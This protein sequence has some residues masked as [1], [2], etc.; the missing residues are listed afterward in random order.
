MPK[1]ALCDDNQDYLKFLK[2]LISE[3]CVNHI[4]FYEYQTGEELLNH[5]QQM[6]DVIILD[7][8]LKGIDG[9]SVAYQLRKTNLDGILVFISGIYSPTPEMF[10]VTPFRF[11]P[12]QYD[13]VR[14]R[15]EI[16]DVIHKLE[17]TYA[18]ER[19][20][21]KTKDATA[22]VKIQD[23]LYISKVKHG[24]QVHIMKEKKNDLPDD[25][26]TK[27]HLKELYPICSRHGFEYAHDSYLVN[28][29]WV[30]HLD[31]KKLLTL[32]GDVKLDVSRSKSEKFKRTLMDYWGNK[33]KRK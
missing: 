19:I 32:R 14:V 33:Y 3:I 31:S 6:H 5:V 27:L 28:C 1:I 24:S 17:S 18:E 2:R 12:K 30:E 7:I 10:K 8:N 29:R 13:E 26:L 16:K 9:I 21:I 22:W 15:E 4:E 20:M 11:I 25:M 23:I